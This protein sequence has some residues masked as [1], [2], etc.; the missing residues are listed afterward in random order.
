MSVAGSRTAVT[1]VPGLDAIRGLAAVYVVL[2][3]IFERAYPGYPADHAPF[4]SGWFIYGRFAVDVFIVLSGF[5]LALGPARRGWRLGDLSDF[6]RRRM[7]RILP[8]YWAALGFSLAV[9]LWIAPQTG[10]G[11]PDAA[12]ALVNGL[13]VQNI[14]GAPSPNRAFWSL[15]VE[16]QLY[17][18]FP[19][20]L[21][22]SRRWGSAAMLASV[23]LVVAIV[24]IA[25]P[26]I[27]RV[28][29]FV[30]QSAPDLAALFAIGMVA[31]GIVARG[32]S[33]WP[34]HWLALGAL[35]PVLALIA[36]Q[37]S[38]WTLGN[39]YWVDLAVAPAIACLLVALASARP[40][41]LVRVLGTRP[42]RRLG[43]S[44]YSLYLIHLP[45]LTVVY[46]RVVR[47]RIAPGNASFLALAAIVVPLTIAASQVFAQCFEL[48]FQRRAGSGL[49][50]RHPRAIVDPRA[51]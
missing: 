33:Q 28:D 21:W 42:L 36:L 15:A 48:P 10:Q 38:V 24:G 17:L 44:S 16:A 18:L 51:A 8:A 37:G 19:A 32:P 43:S 6:A 27:A 34:W 50:S 25:G 46:D 12:S 4:W 35:A 7:R 1:P 41:A 23:A 13:L 39:I 9:A 22:W 47:G 2:N 11:R 30:I 14:V 45:I 40:A 29:T 31:A 3:H 49:A 5:S 26:H 20:L